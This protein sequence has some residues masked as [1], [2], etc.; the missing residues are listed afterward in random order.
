VEP[1]EP[2]LSCGQEPV[3]RLGTFGKPERTKQLD[4]L[5]GAVRH[6][7]EQR[8]TRLLVA[9]FDA[10]AFLA[11]E[12][13]SLQQGL[14]VLDNPSDAE[15]MAAMRSV[16]VAVQLRFPSL[17]ES[18]GVVGHLL[19]MGIPLVVTDAGSFSELREAAVLV[20]PE[21]SAGHLAEAILQA[22][23]SAS[24]RATAAVYRTAHLPEAF[25]AALD[26]LLASH[27]EPGQR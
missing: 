10:G 24:L 3:L 27:R 11:R 19:G 4:R 7:Q 13:L 6:L 14:D 26:G 23:E 25:V 16:D 1:H 18:S 9:G 2:I 17:G 21:V 5:F 12:G 8:P 15:L 20:P 22:H